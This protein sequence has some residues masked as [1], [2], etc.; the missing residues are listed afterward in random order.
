MDDNLLEIRAHDG[1]GFKP[2]ITFGNWRV[3]ILR[4]LDDLSPERIDSMERHTETDEVF[5]LLS[6]KGALI[7]GGNEPQVSSIYSQVLEHGKIY[8]VKRNAWHT[9]LLSRDA[10]VLLVENKDTG[11]YNS[12]Y[13]HLSPEHRYAIVEYAKQAQ[14]E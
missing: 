4:F 9:I 6:G 5:V 12:E 14:F 8:N 2:L 3:A 11:D 10:S 13:S 7:I 1:L